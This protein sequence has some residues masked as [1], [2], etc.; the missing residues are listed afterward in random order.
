MTDFLIKQLPYDL[1][2]QAG[3][4]L[5]G[6]YLK[7]IDLNA[8]VDPH[9]PVQAKRGGIANSD[10]LKSYLGLLRLGK[11]DFEAIEGS[12]CDTFFAQALGLR[13]VPSSATLRQRLDTHAAAWFDLAERINAAVLGMKIGPQGSCLLLYQTVL[14][15]RAK[16]RRATHLSLRRQR[17]PHPKKRHYH[18]HLQQPRPVEKLV[19][20]HLQLQRRRRSELK[21]IPSGNSPAT[22]TTAKA[23]CAKSAWP[24]ADKSAAP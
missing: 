6:K 23:I 11:N 7:R 13:A 9:Y 22:A 19:R 18:R 16:I 10:I 3:L 15:T 17:Q 4:A 12:R 8:L 2:N 20:Q 21:N 1:S 24:M 5:I 14:D